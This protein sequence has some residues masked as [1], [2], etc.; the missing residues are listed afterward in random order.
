MEYTSILPSDVQAFERM[1]EPSRVFADVETRRNYGH[2]ET[3]S[4]TFLSRL[5]AVEP[6]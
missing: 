5:S 4:I 6:V 2:D 1:L 3:E